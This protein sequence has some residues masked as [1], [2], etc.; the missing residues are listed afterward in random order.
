MFSSLLRSTTKKK[1]CVFIP[2]F[3]VPRSR[4]DFVEEF[5]WFW[6]GAMESWALCDHSGR[7]FTQKFV[8]ITPSQ[9]RRK[10]KLTA[11]RHEENNLSLP[12]QK[13]DLNHW[14][15][16]PG[17]GARLIARFTRYPPKKASITQNTPT[18]GYGTRFDV[19]IKRY[20]RKSL[21]HPEHTNTRVRH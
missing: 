17:Y 13:T 7:H 19:Q 12:H 15:Q 1:N 4:E 6:G 2:F 20:P 9:R 5:G 18:R 8:G 10:V 11:A 16:H 3:L 21:N 14:N